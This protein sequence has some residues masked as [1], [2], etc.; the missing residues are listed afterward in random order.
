MECFVDATIPRERQRPLFM[1]PF[2]ARDIY[3]EQFESDFASNHV[4]SDVASNRAAQPNFGEGHQ[5]HQPS[6]RGSKRRYLPRGLPGRCYPANYRPFL[7][8]AALSCQLPPYPANW[9]H[10]NAC[11]THSGAATK[12][13]SKRGVVGTQ[14]RKL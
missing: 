2:L 14:G 10:S 1:P 7:P 3:I 8:T 12:A 13:A 6:V 4:E 5:H 9:T 11:W